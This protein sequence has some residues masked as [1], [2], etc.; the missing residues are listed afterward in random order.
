MVAVLAAASCAT[1][2][3]PAAGHRPRA[4]AGPVPVVLPDGDPTPPPAL[5]NVTPSEAFLAREGEIV[6]G[7]Y[8]TDWANDVTVDL[9]ADVRVTNVSAATSNVMSVD[10]IVDP[11]A[12]PG[13]R[14]VTVIIPDGGTEVAPGALALEPPVSLSFDGTLAQGS[15]VVAHVQV[16]DPSIPLDTTSSTDPFGVTT[17]TNLAPAL[18]PGLS[19]TVLSAAALKTDV[20]IFVDEPLTGPQAFDLVSGPPGGAKDTHFPSP[21]GLD[22]AARTP[23]ALT[24][25]V[26][27]SG[28]TAAKFATGLYSFAPPSASPLILDFAATA[29]APGAEPA[30]LLLPPTGKWVDELTG[31]SLA[32]WATT[33]TD[34][35]FAVFF[36]QSG[37]TGTYAV[38]LTATTPAATA[39]ATPADATMAGAVMASALPFVLTGGQ[40]ATSASVDW[41]QVATGPGDTG[42]RLHVQS[43]GDP[44]TFLDVTIFD[45]DGTTSVGGNES[46]GPVNAFAGPLEPSHTYFVVFSAGAGFSPSHG[47]YV[48]IIR[49]E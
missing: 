34:P 42:T 44:H 48:G 3:S 18:G 8:S 31:G 12:A 36:D 32:T 39:G 47:G 15:I 30:M 46:G 9:G 49:L 43:A 41:V 33:A 38:D 23:V 11:G 22:V 40:L 13:P 27:V 26:A 16:V 7:G 4:D 28:T 20:E 29:S 35:I 2:P 45:S 25:G 6:L 17:Y 14:D 37:A 10:F 21:A 19:G 5:A 1:T 24:P